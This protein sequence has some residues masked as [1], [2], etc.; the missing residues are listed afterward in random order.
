MRSDERS[1]DRLFEAS[2]TVEGGPS[3]SRDQLRE[4]VSV[5]LAGALVAGSLATGA[6]LASKTAVANGSGAKLAALFSSFYAK[7]TLTT[8]IGAV[9]VSGA[10]LVRGTVLSSPSSQ[11]PEARAPEHA[12]DSEKAKGPVRLIPESLSLASTPGPQA[13]PPAV[14]TP[15]PSAAQV[16]GSGTSSSSTNSHKSVPSAAPS[17]PAAPSSEPSPPDSLAEELS[18][19]RAAQSQLNARNASQALG[20]LSRYFRTYPKGILRPEAQAARIKALCLAGHTAEAQREA[21]RFT[22]ANPN[23]PLAARVGG[24]C[25]VP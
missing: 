9:A 16:S 15:E 22:R 4:A 13:V 2:R 10:I 21:G 1:L 19:V 5:K 17:A 25:S 14:V 8:L 23:S 18:L 12:T 6:G 3:P 20:L 11:N 24:G 7:L